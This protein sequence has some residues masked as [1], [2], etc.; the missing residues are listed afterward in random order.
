MQQQLRFGSGQPLSAVAFLGKQGCE[1][2]EG[3]AALGRG[4]KEFCDE[5]A[6]GEVQ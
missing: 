1:G 5:I 4:G 6:A 3:E 2:R